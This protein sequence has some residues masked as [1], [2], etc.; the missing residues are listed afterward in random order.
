[1]PDICSR[2]AASVWLRI[3]CT[4]VVGRDVRSPERNPLF[5][6]RRAASGSLIEI[7]IEI[8]GD[9]PCRTF[10]N[11]FFFGCMACVEE[12]GGKTC[13]GG[14]L[15]RSFHAKQCCK[16]LLISGVKV[17]K[18]F[19]CFCMILY[20]CH[21]KN[22]Y[23]L[24]FICLGSGSSGNSYFLFTEHYG[25]LID[26]GIGIRT[27]KKNFQANGL[28]LA[29]IKAV[30]VTH[31][32]ADH[33][34]AVGYLANDHHLPVYA[35][36]LVHQG[37]NRNYCV[38]AKLKPEHV[39]VVRK[40]ETF[41]LNDFEVTPFDVPHDSSDNVGYSI[42][43]KNINFCLI[44]DAGHIGER[45]GAYISKADYLVLEANHDEDML[46]MGPYPAYLKERISGERG[47][48]SNKCA[49]Q[50]LVDHIT[51]R[52]RHVWLCHVSEEN[53]HPE[54]ARKTVD[55]HLRTFGIIA[56]KDF[57]LDVL[58]RRIPSEIYDLDVFSKKE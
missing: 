46:M 45:F 28:S 23:M 57:E 56:G 40:E 15:N 27:L 3:E 20:L 54:L 42:Q 47:H 31:D 8:S 30:L 10:R 9:E 53:N 37:I 21:L 32:H 19:V 39:C 38:S 25:I 12:E 51:E 36:E 43:Y 35:T 55:A 48:L 1:M 33:I 5:G 34:K 11:L 7:H 18:I 14:N 44:T 29:Q 50:A 6:F 2:H 22:G 58:K 4:E 17:Q 24:K 16:E 52:L 26:A 13:T 41:R 49:A